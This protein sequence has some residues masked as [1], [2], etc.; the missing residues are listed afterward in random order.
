M[1]RIRS[2]LKWL[3]IGTLVLVVIGVAWTLLRNAQ[4]SAGRRAIDVIGGVEVLEPLLVKDLSEGC[5]RMY[6]RYRR[7]GPQKAFA[8]AHDTGACGVSA[9]QMSLG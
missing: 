9:N 6:R 2:I 1:A 3:M 7:A 5:L 8:L 4:E